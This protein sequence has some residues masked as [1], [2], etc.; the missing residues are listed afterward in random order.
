MGDTAHLRIGHCCPDAPNVDV[1]VDGATRFENVEYAAVTDYEPFDP[2]DQKLTIAPAGST[3]TV[4]STRIPLKENTAYTVLAT[5]LITDIEA[6]VL[7]DDPGDVSDEMAQV[8]LVHTSP[9]APPV[10]LTVGDTAVVDGVGFR[11]ASEYRP[12]RPGTHDVG[13]RPDDRGRLELELSAIEFDGGSAYSVVT[14]GQ[15]ETGTLAAVVT[16][17]AAALATV[18]E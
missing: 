14:V 12:V 9:D 18:T 3:A 13:L 17:D 16:E 6:T 11:E 5:G 4:V 7:T 1:A 2:G 10:A 15:I 8:R